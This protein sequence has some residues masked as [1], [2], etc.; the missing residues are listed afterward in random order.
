MQVRTSQINSDCDLLSNERS[1]KQKKREAVASPSGDSNVSQ[2]V[3]PLE[4]DEQKT[5]DEPAEAV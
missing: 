5:F 3:L 4:V 2:L 1:E